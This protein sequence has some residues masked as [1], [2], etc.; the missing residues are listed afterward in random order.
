MVSSADSGA[1]AAPWW[2]QRYLYVSYHLH[3][4]NFFNGQ[5]GRRKNGCGL[6]NINYIV[7]QPKEAISCCFGFVSISFFALEINV[8]FVVAKLGTG[9]WMD[10]VSIALELS[11]ARF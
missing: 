3:F 10:F 6:S 1:P 2:Q 5:S 7:L 9:I 8:R 4:F 11:A